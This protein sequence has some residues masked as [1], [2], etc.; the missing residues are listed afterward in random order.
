LPLSVKR[1][2]RERERETKELGKR[3]KTSLGECATQ[4]VSVCNCLAK[5]EAPHQDNIEKAQHAGTEDADED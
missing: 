4:R 1:A 3:A 2:R 5:N